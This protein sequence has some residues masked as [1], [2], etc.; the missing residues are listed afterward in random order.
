[1]NQIKI[2]GITGQARSGKDTV[3]A[4]L[5]NRGFYST[6]FAAPIRKFV[7][8]L[9][10]IQL[11]ELERIKETPSKFGPSPR[12]MMQ[13][14]GTEWGRDT[15]NKNIWAKTCIDNISTD[16]IVTDV[17]FDNEAQQIVDRGGC[18]LKIV[19]DGTPRVESHT[20]ERGVDQSLVHYTIY[21]SGTLVELESEVEQFV[22]WLTGG[23]YDIKS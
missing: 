9:L 14:L 7:C 6:S 5:E 10:G 20:S 2:V 4:M 12:R 13:T 15:I 11:V 23:Y 21:N 18:I 22:V 17:R 1:M 8:N 19:R 3:G 16:T